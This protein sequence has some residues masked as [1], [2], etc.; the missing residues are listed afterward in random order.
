MPKI[1]KPSALDRWWARLGPPRDAVPAETQRAG[2]PSTYVAPP[3]EETTGPETE[4]AP[5]DQLLLRAAT[6]RAAVG[7][8]DDH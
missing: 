2:H 1:K 6:Q 7:S 5:L 4:S 8:P 3:R